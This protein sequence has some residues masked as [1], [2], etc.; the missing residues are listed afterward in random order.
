[1]QFL[2]DCEELDE[3]SM[4]LTPLQEQQLI[5]E[6]AEKGLDALDEFMKREREKGGLLARKLKKLRERLE[7]Q[8]RKLRERKDGE[9]SEEERLMQKGLMEEISGL[10]LNRER[11]VAA[12]EDYSGISSME[13]ENAI[14]DDA[15]LNLLKDLPEV[16]DGKGW[17]ERLSDFI[18]RVRLLLLRFWKWLLRLLGI[19]RKIKTRKD[20]HTIVFASAAGQ[21]L[22]YELDASVARALTSE[23]DFKKRLDRELDRKGGMSRWRRRPDDEDYREAAKRMVEEELKLKEQKK[24]EEIE[25]KKAELKERIEDV[26]QEQ[27][28]R[29][30]QAEEDRRAMMERYER[31]MEQLEKNV[32]ERPGEL[33]RNSLVRELKTSGYLA[34]DEEGELIV[35]TAL[36]Q[37]FADIVLAGELQQLPSGVQARFGSSENREGIYEKDRMLMSAEASRMDIVESLIHARLYHPEDR[38]IADD[39]IV[40]NRELT[41]SKTHVIILMDRSDSMHENN[42]MLAAKKAVLAL[43]RAVMRKGTQN[44]VDVV[45][46]D[47]TVDIIDLMEVWRAEPRGFTNTA[48]ALHMANRLFRESRADIRLVYLITDGLPEAY[49]NSKGEDV[50]SSPGKCLPFAVEEARRLEKARLTILLLEPGDPMYMTA[51][52]KIAEATRHSRIIVTDPNALAKEVLEDFIAERK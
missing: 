30:R 34:E 24:M 22:A 52:E 16:E 3:L 1:M 47:T 4:E 21:Q 42:R 13:L 32:R 27:G 31:E 23:T 37:R 39:D 29:L 33:L 20:G 41:G 5:A 44:I 43:Y 46:F 18:Y 26:K 19:G 15:F 7:A 35:T 38:H 10:K 11:A 14:K 50:A 17:R 2:P 49:T 28:K 12:Y 8:A 25:R 51:A 48:G 36:V 6:L 45:G 9:L 40:I